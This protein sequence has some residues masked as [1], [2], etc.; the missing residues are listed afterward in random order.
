LHG[1]EKTIH[2]GT[3]LV[4]SAVLFLTTCFG[5]SSMFI[6]GLY[7]ISAMCSAWVPEYLVYPVMFT[8]PYMVIQ[9][10]M[11][12]ILQV[13][14]PL[15]GRMGPDVPAE[16]IISVI[17]WLCVQL[18]IVP[19]LPLL[20]RLHATHRARPI[21]T[22]CLILTLTSVLVLIWL[23]PRNSWSTPK[24]L[25]LMHHY[26][27]ETEKSSLHLLK[28]DSTPYP[29]QVVESIN[30]ILKSSPMENVDSQVRYN[31]LQS[32]YPLNEVAHSLVWDTS[33]MQ[34]KF[35]VNDDVILSTAKS[36]VTS[37][38]P[39]VKQ[40][41]IQKFSNGTKSVM[42]PCAMNAHNMFTVIAFS[43]NIT[44]A[45]V[46]MRTG[47]YGRY[48]I[49]QSSGGL[50]SI[51]WETS[52]QEDILNLPQD[53]D[54]TMWMPAGDSVTLDLAASSKYM[55]SRNYLI[56][57]IMGLMPEEVDVFSVDAIHRRVQV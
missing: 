51:D 44:S 1:S 42:V 17:V 7:V 39:R 46:P 21:K 23:V 30:S 32:M 45:S 24:R 38:A 49:R 40:I 57:R 55:G 19:F 22:L 56:K 5:L 9:P 2:A 37:Y 53:C 54:V 47:K 36:Y 50:A 26:D 18:M 34:G 13:F 11:M 10:L 29:K 14:V 31:A 33:K 28:Q 41:R 6:P 52:A 4:H 43:A 12:G 8:L 20:F 48:Y 15:T 3:F 35:W 27:M 16:I 25:T